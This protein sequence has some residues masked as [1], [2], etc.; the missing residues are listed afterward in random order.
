MTV[1]RILA[2]IF[3]LA[4]TISISGC[5][6][7]TSNSIYTDNSKSFIQ[8][9][10]ENISDSRY[11]QFVMYDPENSVMYMYSWDYI[12]GG[13][14]V[15]AMYNADGSLRTYDTSTKIS[16]LVMVS[17]GD[18]SDS[19]YKQ[20]VMY[21]PETSVMYMY[22]WDYIS[23]GST[24]TA[25]YNADGSLRT[26]DTSTKISSLVMVS[27]GDI[28]DSRYKQFVMYDPETSVMYMYSWDY[29]SG[30]STVTAMYNADNSLK[31]LK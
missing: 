12:S 27:S 22:S 19:R 29:I 2:I 4:I 14:T 25:M 10:S 21:D 1:K 24:V 26:Y 6:S 15:T 31:L 13:S 11:K 20:F 17:S 7:N 5:G 3:A 16:S 28:S 18:I 23:G 30:G 9:F 8:I